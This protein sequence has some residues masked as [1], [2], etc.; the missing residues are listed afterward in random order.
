LN[1]YIL[2][3]LNL[4]YYFLA[5]VEWLLNQAKE[6]LLDLVEKE[7]QINTNH[8]LIMLNFIQFQPTNYNILE[9]VYLFIC[10]LFVY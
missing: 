5:I 10:I 6:Y 8:Q 3:Y 7:E 9:F 4:I 1:I 2:L